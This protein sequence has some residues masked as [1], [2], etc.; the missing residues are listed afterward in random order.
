[1]LFCNV[2]ILK[3]QTKVN[4]ACY[5]RLEKAILRADRWSALSP[6][7]PLPFSPSLLAVFKFWRMMIDKS[8]A[9]VYNVCVRNDVLLWRKP[10]PL[11][12]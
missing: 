8:Y 4:I 7:T 2:R 5:L 10:K 6:Y 11:D 1:M 9:L 3:I 12:L